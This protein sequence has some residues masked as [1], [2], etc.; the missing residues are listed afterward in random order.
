MIMENMKK[1]T[2]RA[3]LTVT[4][5]SLTMAAVNL[6]PVTR[7]ATHPTITPVAVS[8]APMTVVTQADCDDVTAPPCVTLDNVDADGGMS[9]YLVTPGARVPM[10]WLGSFEGPNGTVWHRVTRVTARK[11]A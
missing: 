7:E 9:W 1:N 2:I 6:P 5:V 11:A 3:G 4:A 8:P 10:M